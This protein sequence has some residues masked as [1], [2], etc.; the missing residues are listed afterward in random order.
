[1]SCV[2]Y[3]RQ[4]LAKHDDELGIERQEKVCR[5]VAK[6]RGLRVSQVL[7]DNNTSASKRGR[8]AYTQLTEMMASGQVST[9]IILRI[10]RLLRLN[11]EL[12]ELIQLVEHHPVT[13][14]TAEGEIDLSTPQGRLIARILVSVARSEI[15][16][17]SARHKLANEQAALAGK[18]HGSRRPYGYEADLVTINQTE[19]AVLR[20]MAR[21]VIDGMSYR[22]VAYWLNESGYTTTLG[23][24]WYPITVRNLLKKPRYGGY[25][26]YNGEVVGLG[27]WEPIF[28]EE[29]Y[30]LLH[31]AIRRG[32][33]RSTIRPR[34][35]LLTGLLYCGKCGQPLN[36]E[37]KRDKPER[38]LRRTYQCRPQGDTQRRGGCG[39]VTRNADALEEWLRQC[40]VYRLDTPGLMSLLQDSSDSGDLSELL[41]KRHA[42]QTRKDALLDDYA[43]GTLSKA[44]YK[45]AVSRVERASEAIQ[46]E[47]DQLAARSLKLDLSGS[48]TV[49]EAWDRNDRHWRRQLIDLLIER[50]DIKPGKSKPFFPM[51]DGSVARFDPALVEITWRV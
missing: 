41:K 37:T 28:D 26:E 24:Q 48:E 18:P 32:Q 29:T 7:T 17:K 50:V 6:A 44:D 46:R 16:I 33:S 45:R 5:A 10:D 19:A 1:M 3:R 39:G 22:H 40:V 36:G 34:K 42:L 30:E 23:K 11:D 12:E 49:A 2:I 27:V 20:K 14:I 35:Y 13:V 31:L 15:E 25:R 4:S 8:P 43:D 38:P 51:P 21:L 47:I 9:V